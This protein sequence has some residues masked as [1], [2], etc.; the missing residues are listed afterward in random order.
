MPTKNETT[1]HESA[2][3]LPINEWNIE[4][5]PREKFLKSGEQAL[6]DAELIAILIRFGFRGTSALDIS[7][8]ILNQ[9]DVTRLSTLDVAFLKNIA[10]GK[11]KKGREIK[12]GAPRA[13]SVASAFAL[14]RRIREGK[15]FEK[16]K[17]LY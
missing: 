17:F 15:F 4:E 12:L 14:A 8:K 9:F 7:R 5:R 2:K 13:L 10:I 6:S 1:V 3:Y 16:T 11:T